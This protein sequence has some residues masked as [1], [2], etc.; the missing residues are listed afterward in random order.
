MSG[1]FIS[2]RRDDKVAAAVARSLY[3]RLAEHFGKE[4][5]FMDIDTLKAGVDFVEQRDALIAMIGDEWQ[6]LGFSFTAE[7]DSTKAAGEEF[8]SVVDPTE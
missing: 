3:D 1:I 8:F 2:Y 6:T 7:L 4:H 5:I